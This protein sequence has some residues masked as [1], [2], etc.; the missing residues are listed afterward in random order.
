M[1]RGTLLTIG[2]VVLV[3][4]APTGRDRADPTLLSADPPGLHNV[5]RATPTTWSGSEPQGA[6]AFAQ[7]RSLGVRTIVSVDGAVPNIAAAKANG[8]RYVHIPIG[9]DGIPEAARRQL[10]AVAKVAEGPIYI[11]CHHGRH[12]GPAAAA[13]V[14]R[15]LGDYDAATAT[16]LLTLAKTGPE[17][18]GLWR[19]VAVPRLPAGPPWPE[20]PA[21][22]RVP[23]LAAAMAIVD[24][25]WDDLKACQSAGWRT[26]PGHPDVSPAQ[27][28]LLVFEGL[29]ESK[30]ATD[31]RHLDTAFDRAESIAKQLRSDLA[32]GRTDRADELLKS[33]DGSCKGCHAAARN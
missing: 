26:P 25:H 20:L 2:A 17:Y 32:V 16:R 10:V 22:A 19:D 6:E 31:R 30:R 9:Y 33:L 21:V 7:L 14:G 12:R 15:A 4:T 8:I 29:R 5:I 13:I 23:S 1:I 28:A 3:A 18:A 27:S 11:H 24:R